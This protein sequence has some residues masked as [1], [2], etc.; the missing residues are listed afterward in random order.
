MYTIRDVARLAGV[1]VATVSGV[2]N[3]KPTIKRTL[4]QRVK[5]AMVTLDYHPDQVARSLRARRTLTIGAV[6]A[7]ITNPFYA[8]VIRGAEKEAQSNGYSVFLCDASEDPALESRYLSSLFSRRVDGV[9]LAPTC[10]SPVEY[11][12]MQ[13]RFPMVL[14]DGYPHGFR[15]AAVVTDSVTAAYEATKYLIG[16]GHSRIAIITGRLDLSSGFDR[17]EGFRK[18]LHEERLILN[19]AYIQT[20]NFQTDS[21]YRS[22][23]NLMRL[24]EPPTAIFSCNNQMTLGLMRALR[25]LE[26]PC[27][28]AVSI[29]GFDDFEWSSYFQPRLTAI[30]QPSREMGRQAMQILLRRLSPTDH[31]SHASALEKDAVVMLKAELRIRDS[32]TAPQS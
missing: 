6:I 25:E 30:A 19:E 20:G 10:A 32:T 16:L 27:P 13:K 15:G 1:S 29:L 26:V 2:I 23:L 4:V 28:K 21:G 5:D 14:I 11:A 18:A 3:S 17:L 12:A 7:D 8:D 24:P 9:L 31:E 22:G